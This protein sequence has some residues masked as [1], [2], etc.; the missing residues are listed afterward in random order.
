MNRMLAFG[1]TVVVLIATLILGGESACASAPTVSVTIE[2]PDVVWV[3]DETTF[4]AHGAYELDAATQKEMADGQATVTTKYSWSYAP[5]T[6]VSGGDP[7]NSIMVK[8][9]TDAGA[10]FHTISVTFTVDVTYKDGTSH[11]GNASASKQVKVKKRTL[12]SLTSAKGTIC[13]GA[14]H[15]SVHQTLLHAYVTDGFDAL[16]G[17]SVTFAIQDHP[18]VNTPAELSAGGMS[19][20][21]VVVSTDN[22][23]VANALL[24]SPD[25]QGSVQV[26]AQGGWEDSPKKTCT[27]SIGLPSSEGDPLETVVA[28]ARSRFLSETLSF[29]GPVTGHGVHFQVQGGATYGYADDGYTNEH[30]VAT[31][32]FHASSYSGVVSVTAYDQTCYDAGGQHPELDSF[33]IT[34][35]RVDHLEVSN[36]YFNGSEWVNSKAPGQFITIRAVLS[37]DVQPGPEDDVISWAGGEAADGDPLTRLVSRATSGSHSITATVGSSSAHVTVAVITVAY[38]YVVSGAATIDEDNA[39]CAVDQDDTQGVLLQAHITPSVSGI[40]EFLLVWN[41]GIGVT[42]R[43]DQRRLT[44]TAPAKQF[45]AC[46]CGASGDNITVWSIQAD[47]GIGGISEEDEDTTPASVYVNSDDDNGNHNPDRNENPVSGENDLITA[48]LSILPE[49]VPAG[50]VHVQASSKLGLWSDSAKTSVGGGPYNIAQMPRSLYVEGTSVSD[51]VGDQNATLSYTWGGLS[52]TDQVHVTVLPKDGKSEAVLELYSDANLTQKVSGVAS[53]TVY[54]ALSV[55]IGAGERTTT[56]S[57]TVRIRDLYANYFSGTGVTEDVSVNLASASG[58]QK[59]SGT[60]WE[61]ATEG[62]AGTDN[63]EGSEPLQYRYKIAW[64]TTITPLGNNGRHSITTTSLAGFEEWVVGQGWS[65][66]YTCGPT[67]TEAT[68][69]NVVVGGV[70]VTKGTID[71][72]KWDPDSDDAD[73]KDPVI[74]FNITDPTPHEY[75]WTIY[76]RKTK[77]NGCWTDGEY[78]AATGHVDHA[79]QVEPIHLKDATGGLTQQHEWGTYTYNICVTEKAG[80]TSVDSYSL[81]DPMAM[82]IPD[83]GD[84]GKPGHEVW[85]FAPENG[86]AQLRA[87][88]W[89]HHQDSSIIPKAE[90]LDMVVIDPSLTERA[91]KSGPLEVEQRHAGT[92]ADNDGN[93][94]GISIYEFQD[95]DTAGTWRV[96][97]TASDPSGQR[98][99]TRRT[100]DSERMMVANQALPGALSAANYGSNGLPGGPALIGQARTS[101]S[102]AAIGVNKQVHADQVPIKANFVREA[103]SKVQLV[104]F[105]PGHCDQIGRVETWD[106]SV[107][108]L[109]F[110]RGSLLVTTKPLLTTA[111]G[112]GQYIPWSLFDKYDESTDANS[113]I[114]QENYGKA[115]GTYSRC[116]FAFFSGCDT[117]K[118][119]GSICATLRARGYVANVLGYNRAMDYHVMNLYVTEFWKAFKNP[120][121]LA[122]WR[123]SGLSSAGLRSCAQAGVDSFWT[124][125]TPNLTGEAGVL[126]TLYFDESDGLSTT[127]H[128]DAFA[129]FNDE[130]LR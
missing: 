117:N 109:K 50:S 64:N 94:D 71:Y 95:D 69:S 29:D 129:V 19:G 87:S 27:V 70:T 85:T 67:A 63:K 4:V 112:Q 58:W 25:Q 108:G 10:A 37:P 120:T 11:S 35:V 38:I 78:W 83:N 124:E 93:L 116:S 121:H 30:G 51:N 8:Y 49:G 17:A 48:T 16:A 80:E 36:A 46:V 33:T 24:T 18:Y 23:G 113:G 7:G 122:Y 105:G 31:G 115:N 42:G 102:K 1:L 114:P 79:G 65:N 12:V 74:S 90:A 60:A 127:E 41:G 89:L 39:A 61:N 96:L 119:A 73:L 62:P 86:G 52:L 34:V 15:S 103:L 82:W 53:Q 43:P 66:A 59:Y 26:T 3:Q 44:K 99:A 32:L 106:T 56:N 14:H 101:E 111:W 91:T 9:G 92:D 88:Y 55:I 77:G 97:W 6:K 100:H 130:E 84:D 110:R 72:F 104:F 57:L 76:Y 2:G 13:A 128:A 107:L 126:W 125:V 28:V 75:D 118:G 22:D 40:P 21:Q 98:Q 54:A 20:S 47:L 45:V 5:A 81:K 68:T 123:A